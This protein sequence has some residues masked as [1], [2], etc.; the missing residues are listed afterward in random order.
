MVS[1]LP[2]E[3]FPQIEVTFEVDENSIM[4]VTAVD[5]GSGASENLVITNDSGRLS[6]EEIEKMIRDAEINEEFDKVVKA[7]IDAK[8][9]LENYIYSMKNT[10]EDKEKLADKLS[11]SDKSTVQNAVKEHQDWLSANPEAEKE[12]YESH[13]KELQSVCDPIVA[14]VY[15]QSGGP[16]GAQEAP[17]DPDL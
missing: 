17:E 3:E 4:K 1:Q 12:D 14:K 9:S 15:K 16:G 2:Q 13:L 8:N 6:K 10:V 5:K 11:E 7:K